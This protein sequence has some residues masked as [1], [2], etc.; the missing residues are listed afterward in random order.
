MITIPFVSV[1]MTLHI[2]GLTCWQNYLI[3]TLLI[4]K[5]LINMNDLWK[6]SNPFIH[7]I[8]LFR[9][10]NTIC[11]SKMKLGLT[12]TKIVLN[13]YRAL[14]QFVDPSVWIFRVGFVLPYHTRVGALTAM[15]QYT[16]LKWSGHS[17]WLTDV[18]IITYLKW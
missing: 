12:N 17:D 2:T 11:F 15:V 16:N 4:F 8:N 18:S 9:Y 10:L 14:Q 5:A 3:L 7:N 1:C 13:T 6:G